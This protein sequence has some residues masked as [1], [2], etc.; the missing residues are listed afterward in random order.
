MSESR[1]YPTRPFIGVGVVVLKE[2]L[3]LLIRRGKP[4]KAGEWSLPGGS[5]HVG[6]TVRET[7]SR[8]VR[9]ETGVE[10]REL[11]FLEV[12]DAIIPD[13]EGRVQFHYTLI[14][15]VAQWESGEP[16]ADDDAEHAV[17]VPLSSLPEIELW[18]KTREI[19]EKA[20]RLREQRGQTDE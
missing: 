20:S 15:F 5:Q 13:R 9:E 18:E 1:E 14:D 6:E 17:W 2:D 10:I 3:V 11:I 7:A 16:N 8:E 19:I 4:P 12:I